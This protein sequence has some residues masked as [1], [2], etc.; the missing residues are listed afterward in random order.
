MHLR[1]FLIVLVPRLL[2]SDGNRIEMPLIILINK[3]TFNLSPL[4]MVPEIPVFGVCP[5]FKIQ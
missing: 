4:F 3:Q 2:A 5:Q 1:W